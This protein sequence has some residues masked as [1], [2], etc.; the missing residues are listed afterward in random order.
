MNPQAILHVPEES[1]ELY[2]HA[3]GWRNFFKIEPLETSTINNLDKQDSINIVVDGD[4]LI[5]SA[6]EESYFTI[7]SDNGILIKSGL[8]K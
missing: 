6:S 2:R 8:L 5:L 7:F 1:I 4:E 3:P